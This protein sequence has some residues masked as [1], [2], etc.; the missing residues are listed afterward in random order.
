MNLTESQRAR[1]ISR[2]EEYVRAQRASG[3]NR[4]GSADGQMEVLRRYVSPPA[5]VVFIGCGDGLEVF[6]ARKAGYDA[7][8]VT[9]G[10]PD[11]DRAKSVYRLDLTLCDAHLLPDEWADRFDI[12][13]AFQTVEH[14]LSP[15]L[16]LWEMHRILKPGGRFYCEVPHQSFCISPVWHHI[17]SPTPEQLRG[18]FMK[19]EYK[20]IDTGFIGEDRP[21]AARW[22]YGTAIR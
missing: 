17:S 12:A 22:A 14:S 7:V 6:E 15:M 13:L 5:Q 1:L 4:Y 8:G 20:A 16:L 18:W 3:D 11:V 21:D 19:L 10:Q 9:L 2:W